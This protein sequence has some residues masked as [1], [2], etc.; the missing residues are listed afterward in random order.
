MPTSKGVVFCDINHRYYLENT[1]PK[2]YF[3]EKEEICIALLAKGFTNREIAE[4]MHSSLR[5][6][7]TH[8][9]NLKRK[10]NCYSKTHLFKILLE[11]A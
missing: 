11:L 3:T 8:I 9:V 10:F 6:V 5:T 7:D 2:V 1:S 4:K